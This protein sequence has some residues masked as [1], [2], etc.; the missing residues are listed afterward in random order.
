MGVKKGDP[1]RLTL[2]GGLSEKRANEMSVCS[3]C[4]FLCNDRM[5]GSNHIP[6]V[7]W[8]NKLQHN[9]TIISTYY[10]EL[11]SGLHNN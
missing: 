5:F 2:L 7:G 8:C 6:Q 10:M 3:F 4:I 11:Y 9:M 1:E